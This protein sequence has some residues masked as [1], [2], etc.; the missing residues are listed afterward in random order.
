MHWTWVF[1]GFRFSVFRFRFRYSPKAENRKRKTVMYSTIRVHRL[2]PIPELAVIAAAAARHANPMNPS[3]TRPG[4]H[5]QRPGAPKG[6]R[7]ASKPW[8]SHT[9][10]SNGQDSERGAS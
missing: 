10:G 1:L 8:L 9:N 7:H 4:P 5:N 6:A 2:Q 3:T